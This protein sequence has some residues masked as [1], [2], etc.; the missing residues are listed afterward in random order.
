M[1]Y[2]FPCLCDISYW[3]MELFRQC[4]NFYFS[5]CCTFIRY[6]SSLSHHFTNS[7]IYLFHTNYGRYYKYLISSVFLNTNNYFSCN[8][9]SSSSKR[10]I[11]IYTFVCK[12]RGNPITNQTLDIYDV[13][14]TFG[15]AKY[16]KYQI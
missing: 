13:I 15:I 12:R 16:H 9:V 8:I 4:S 11:S 14:P 2:F 10:K 7:K 1:Y 5:F 6:S 3:I